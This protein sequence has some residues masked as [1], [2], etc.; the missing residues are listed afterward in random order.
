MIKCNS[1][2]E[3][4]TISPDALKSSLQGI[5][6]EPISFGCIT[7]FPEEKGIYFIVRNCADDSPIYIGSA[8]S[9]DRTI[10]IRCRQYRQKGSGGKSVRSRVAKLLRCS[11]SEAITHIIENFSIRYIMISDRSRCHIEQLEQ[12]C[13]WAYRPMLNYIKYTFEYG[14]L[15]RYVC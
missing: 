3:L 9:E 13:I 15:D 2:D 8:N 6:S 5:L 4:L 10:K 1:F 14:E 11:E 12:A 7:Q